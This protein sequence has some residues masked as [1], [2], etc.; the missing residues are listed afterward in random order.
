[1]SILCLDPGTKTGWCIYDDGKI[2]SGVIDLK[3]N[4]HQG[5][6]M[7]YLKL[8]NFMKECCK[9]HDLM[10]VYFEEVHAHKGTYAAQ[11]YGGLSA[12]IMKFCEKREIPYRGIR[13][14]DIKRAVTGRGNATKDC[15]IKAVKKLG[16][17]PADDN[18]ADAIALLYAIQSQDSLD[19]IF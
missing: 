13:V 4:R 6:G 11:I 3:P 16:H 5:G 2:K 12:T 8:H 7:R 14:A 1:M 15:V 10:E 19:D 18:E 9:H 17:N